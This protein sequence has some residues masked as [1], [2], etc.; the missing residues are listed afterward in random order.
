M[1]GVR[2]AATSRQLLLTVA[3]AAGYG[4]AIGAGKNL[5]YAWRSA[6]KVPLLL[7]GTAL[8]CTALQFVLARFAAVPLPF[9]ATGRTA[10]AFARAMAVALASLAPVSLFL[11][12]TMVRPDERGLGGYPG[13]VLANM[14]F[15]AAAGG[16]AVVLQARALRREATISRLRSAA[17]VGSWLVVSLLVGGQLAFWLRPF[18]GIASLTGAPP[19]VLG[20][21]PTV[22]GARNFYEVVWQFV[23]GSGQP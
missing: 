14:G 19:F 10:L 20:D 16:V 22:T 3:A 18:F 21:E 13:F 17:L 7:L 2:A 5:T 15:V 8:L 6:I 1:A 11:G 9:A 4:F 23:S 12:R